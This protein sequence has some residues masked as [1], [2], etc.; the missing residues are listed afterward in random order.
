MIFKFASYLLITYISV[1]LALYEPRC[2]RFSQTYITSCT[3]SQ[4][5]LTVTV[6]QQKSHPLFA[7]HLQ[8]KPTFC[9]VLRS[10]THIIPSIHC[11]CIR[12]RIK[13][14]DLLFFTDVIYQDV[15]SETNWLCYAGWSSITQNKILHSVFLLQNGGQCGRTQ[16]IQHS[17]F[18]F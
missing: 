13:D 6:Y 17:K 7:A 9:C 12:V 5:Y 11:V 18:A 2:Q 10:T 15:K 4:S 1:P 14:V 3:H 8:V 16:S